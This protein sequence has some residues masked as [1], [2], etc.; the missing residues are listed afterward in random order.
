[1]RRWFARSGK[2]HSLVSS[3][4]DRRTQSLVSKLYHKHDIEHYYK[5]LENLEWKF[6]AIERLVNGTE[7]IF[8]KCDKFNREHTEDMIQHFQKFKPFLA[9]D[10]DNHLFTHLASAHDKFEY[11]SFSQR[12]FH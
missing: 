6:D 11:A 9:V 12:F 10:V 8:V 3:V 4:A 1:M 7:T 5:V 2:G